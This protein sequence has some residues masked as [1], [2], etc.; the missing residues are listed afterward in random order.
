M[1][2]LIHQREIISQIYFIRG[3]KVMLDFH[4]AMLYNVETRVLKQQVRRNIDRF[5]DD[6]MFQLAVSEWKELITNCDNLGAMKYSPSL[7]YAFTEQGIAMLSGVLRSSRAIKINISI[8]RAFIRMREIIDENK[9]LR[10][11]LDALEARYD[12]QFRIVFE[13]MRELITTKQK[14]VPPVGFRI[15][16]QSKNEGDS[17]N[18]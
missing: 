4:L 10:N 12:E 3:K 15:N 14:P 11:K 8:M 18:D 7:P 6:F 13:A 1:K 9:E 2:G 17:D 5:P 16:K